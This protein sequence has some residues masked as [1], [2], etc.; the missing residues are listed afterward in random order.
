MS[1]FSTVLE[2]LG[3]K[4]KDEE[5]KADKGKSPTFDRT[6]SAD[7]AEAARKLYKPA[8]AKSGEMEMVDV[9]A[10]LD[11]LAKANPEKLNWKESIVDLLKL[12][13]IDSS[14]EAREEMAKE[15]G[16]PE[17]KMKDSAS[18]NIWLHKEVMRRIAENG[19]NVPK[20]LLD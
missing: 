10:K 14:R 9:V 11:G 12:L 20:E 19:G 1:L 5:P 17:E 15:L 13:D 7:Q 2:K 18:M 16:I 4:K 6:M 3:L 8:G